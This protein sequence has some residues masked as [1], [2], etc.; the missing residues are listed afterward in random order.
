MEVLL[1]FVKLAGYRLQREIMYG[2]VLQD[3]PY[4]FH[5]FLR[6]LFSVNKIKINC[7]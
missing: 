6:K 2:F 3:L 4:V 7:L 5:L 1:A